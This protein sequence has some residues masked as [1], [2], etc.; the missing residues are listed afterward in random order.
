MSFYGLENE[1]KQQ[2]KIFLHTQ[3]TI[4]LLLTSS[5]KQKQNKIIIEVG[6]TNKHRVLCTYLPPHHVIRQ[7]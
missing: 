4:I 1:V 7:K 6:Q 2:K 5:I 3:I